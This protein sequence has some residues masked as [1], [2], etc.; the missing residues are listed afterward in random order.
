[1]IRRPPRSTLFPYTTLFRSASMTLNRLA[2]LAVQQSKDRSQ[3]QA[4]LEQAWH[5]AETSSDQRALAETECNRAQITA[6]MWDDPKS[7][8]VH[9]ERALSLARGI[10]DTEL[11]ARSL[12]SLGSIHI[13]RG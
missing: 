4:L 6:I 7:A 10:Q 9:G 13:L 5:M 12:S 3:V 2:I 1:M 11:E 8:S